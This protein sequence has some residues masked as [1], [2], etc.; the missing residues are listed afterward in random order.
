MMRRGALVIALIAVT[1]YAGT[2]FSEDDAQ[3][4]ERRNLGQISCFHLF[5][6]SV[7]EQR[8][9]R[10][11]K[12]DVRTST[13]LKV[14][15]F[16]TPIIMCDFWRVLFFGRFFSFYVLENFSLLYTTNRSPFL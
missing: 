3:F 1:S 11:R 10:R 16:L 13:S 12:D 8:V 6:F 15:N 4:V 9:Q 5:F 2:C 14:S 7:V